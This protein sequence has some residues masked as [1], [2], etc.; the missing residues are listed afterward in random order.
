MGVFVLIKQM[1]ITNSTAKQVSQAAVKMR[2]CIVQVEFQQGPVLVTAL[3]AC[4]FDK[5]L[6][7]THLKHQDSFRAEMAEQYAYHL[8]NNF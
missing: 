4:T 6:I 2:A 5:S 7:K 1:H 8:R 3:T